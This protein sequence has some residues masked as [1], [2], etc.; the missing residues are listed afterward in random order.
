MNGSLRK[1]LVTA[2]LRFKSLHEERVA[3]ALN[4]YSTVVFDEV[5]TPLEV[6]KRQLRELL[7]IG[8]HG[9]QFIQI[10]RSCR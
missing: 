1:L 8:C 4:N 3:C 2:S 5:P 7:Q 6:P 10:I 9:R